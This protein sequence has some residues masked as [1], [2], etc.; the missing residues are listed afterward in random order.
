[1][2]DFLEADASYA[3]GV[4][5]AGSHPGGSRG[6]RDFVEPDLEAQLAVV[7]GFADDPA[8]EASPAYAD[9][10]DAYFGLL[11]FDFETG[12]EVGRDP[13]VVAEF[14]GSVIM[15]D[16]GDHEADRFI[17]RIVPE[18][19]AHAVMVKRFDDALRRPTSEGNQR[20]RRNAKASREVGYVF[21]FN[22]RCEKYDVDLAV[23]FGGE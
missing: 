2:I 11:A 23:G 4:A 19:P 7:S 14:K 8:D 5:L 18:V 9:V 15:K 10:A 3:K 17:R 16:T 6:D 21:E 22:I 12:F 20:V 1:M 13:Q